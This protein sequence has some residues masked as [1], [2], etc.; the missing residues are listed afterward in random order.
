ML[1]YHLEWALFLAMPDP[2]AHN[3]SELSN[4]HSLLLS[5]F[6]SSAFGC[7][8]GSR[9]SY[10]KCLQLL[11][12]FK[13]SSSTIEVDS[14]ENMCMITTHLKGLGASYN[15]NKSKLIIHKTMC[16]ITPMWRDMGQAAY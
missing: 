9:N 1:G 3:S 12:R 4:N 15:L 5:P 7:A 2:H 6:V 14:T 10:H 8:Y 11:I 16:T 13:S